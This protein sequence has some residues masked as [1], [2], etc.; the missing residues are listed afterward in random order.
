MEFFKNF[1]KEDDTVVG[2]CAFKNRNKRIIDSYS[3]TNEFE[4]QFGATKLLYEPKIKSGMFM[5]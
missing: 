2:L 3:G 4:R 5:F 1:Y